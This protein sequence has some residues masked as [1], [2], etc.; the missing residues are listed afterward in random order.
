MGV[1]RLLVALALLAGL[2]LIWVG[3]ELS[4]PISAPL[5]DGVFV[6][7]SYRYV[8]PPPGAAGDPFPA[9]VTQAVTGGSVPLLALA[10]A[11]VPPQAQIVA[12]ADALEIT[13]AVSSIAVSIAP[14]ASSD[15]R[16]SGN[17]YTITATDQAGSALQLKPSV[18]V[19]VVLRA[20]QPGPNV[21]IGRLDGQRWVALPTDR[22]SILDILSA[23]VEQLGA[24]AVLVGAGSSGSPSSA[25]SSS[26]A[27]AA[28]ASPGPSAADNLPA[29][30]GIPLSVV[31]LMVI[32][33]V[34]AG[35]AWAFFVDGDKGRVR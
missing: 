12:Q 3:Q 11:E 25:P 5:F 16:V 33:A 22:S 2:G 28:S 13:S 10:T 20:P 1:S 35:I 15:P 30:G 19:T 24:F 14:S 18:L 32:A 21:Q 17:V 26:A 31:A 4:P 7:E 9:Q 6:E 27:S 8:D 34:G 23:N 29:R